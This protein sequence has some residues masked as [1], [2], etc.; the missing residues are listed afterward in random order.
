MISIKGAHRDACDI[1]LASVIELQGGSATAAETASAMLARLIGSDL[2][3]S[4]DP[5]KAVKGD[6]GAERSAV[7]FLTHD[8][9]AR[10]ARSA[11]RISL[12]PNL[13]A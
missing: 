8:A 2:F 13:F 9:V 3:L 1:W 5:A 12:K 7:R 11:D 6:I 10:A 4:A